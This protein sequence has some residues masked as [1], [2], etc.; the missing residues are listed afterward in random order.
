M[1]LASL[2]YL[3]V[4]FI[5]AILEFPTAYA[6][7][8]EIVYSRC[9]RTTTTYDLTGTVTIKG[10]TQTITRT[11]DGLDIYDVLPD[12]T[13]FLSGFT[14]PC[15]LVFRD[16]NG[17]ETVIYDCSSTSTQKSACAA[18]DPAVSFDGKTIAFSVFRGALK[19]HKE[20]IDSRVIHPDADKA[21]LG[22]YTLPNK[23]LE[24]TGSHLLFYSIDTKKTQ[25]TQFVPGVYD[26]G[27][28][29]ISNTRIAFTSTRDGNT[30]TIIWGT[31]GSRAGTRIWT[32]DIDGKNP[33]L[34]SHHSLS[35][36]QHPF[37]LRDGRLAYS[38]WQ[39]F[40]GRPFR[41]PNGAAGGFDTPDN[42]FHIYA[43][44]PDGAGNFPIYGQHSGNHSPSY[45]GEDHSAAH[46]ITQTSDDRVWFADYYRGNNNGLGA[47]IGVI[48]EPKGQEGISPQKA[49]HHGDFYVPRDVINFAA[50]T[51]NGDTM[52][53]VLVS[54]TITHPNYND[55][56][57]FAGRLGHPSDFSPSCTEPGGNH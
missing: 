53:M 20:T 55:F 54:P 3:F 34:A 4:F 50:W 5:F 17:I 25:A 29:F 1:L 46:F 37:M 9:E 52:S 44:D 33:D 12:V 22:F 30:T 10:Q 14:A 24:S 18:L 48:P 7:D 47:L 31:T 36:E 42:Q 38:S 21:N 56:I 16:S 57:P 45:F 13:N 41:Y 40:G 15:D 32:V 6:Q 19:N 51:N 49:T 23:L 39:I 26:S 11:M 2:K 28:A 43:Q 27:P 8:T 35:Q